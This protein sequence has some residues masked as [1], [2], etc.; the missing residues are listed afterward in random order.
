MRTVQRTRSEVPVRI[1]EIE[2]VIDEVL[3][4][5]HAV[6]ARKRIRDLQVHILQAPDGIGE[7][8]PQRHLQAVV[9]RSTRGEQHLVLA[10][11]GVLTRKRSSGVGC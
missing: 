5:R 1:A 7:V 10:K 11:V 6:E 4:I 9:D 8:L 2:G 3:V